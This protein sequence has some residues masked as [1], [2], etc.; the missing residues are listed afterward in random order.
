MSQ[1]DKGNRVNKSQSYKVLQLSNITRVEVNLSQNK[2][3]HNNNIK[4]K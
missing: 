2:N 4:N 3:Q 1:Q